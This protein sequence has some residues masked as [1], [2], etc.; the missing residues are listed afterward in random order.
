MHGLPRDVD[1]LLR[2]YE[3]TIRKAAACSVR[4][5][6][7]IAHFLWCRR[8]LAAF[9]PP[10]VLTRDQAIAYLGIG[11]DTWKVT[12]R[13]RWEIL[14]VPIEG[15]YTQCG[16]KYRFS[17][18][19]RLFEHRELVFTRTAMKGFVDPVVPGL[20]EFIAAQS[21]RIAEELDE[22]FVFDVPLHLPQTPT[23]LERAYSGTVAKV[24]RYRLKYGLAV[25]DAINDIWVKL[26]NSNVVLKF[27]RSAAKHL[28][29]QLCTDDVLDFLGIEWSDWDEM[30]RT[31][32]KAPNP[33]KGSASSLDSVYRTDDIRALDES[34]YFK[35]RI[36]RTLP[37]S[38]VAPGSFERY[39]QTAIE[40]TL[41]NIFR[42]LDRHSNKE[43]TFGEGTCIQENRR[44]RRLD[45][46]SFDIAWEDTLASDD[47]PPE[48]LI[49]IARRARLKHPEE[50]GGSGEAS[51]GATSTVGRKRQVGDLVQVG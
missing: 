13:R 36:V 23:Q 2:I 30:M 38:C 5:A 15:T 47:V 22:G 39:L 25:E 48:H 9:R 49:D 31:Y 14:P 24:I 46:D 4:R 51:V 10:Q 32:E 28:P 26:L 17:D 21:K 35:E 6:W 16:S 3:P 8:A 43:D 33:V 44:V 40:R 12:A 18:V 37:A 29:A 7:Q 27:T 50:F 20:E 45:R 34:G 19:Q 11:I 41:K 42:S 1:E